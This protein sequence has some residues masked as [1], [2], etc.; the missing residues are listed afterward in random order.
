M[1]SNKLLGLDEMLKSLDFP[2]PAN[3]TFLVLL[4]VVNFRLDV[5]YLIGSSNKPLTL[6]KML[7][8]FEPENYSNSWSESLK[9]FQYQ[10]H[11][12]SGSTLIVLTQPL[13]RCVYALINGYI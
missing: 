12:S 4:S 11:A 8:D 5:T 3:T 13:D 10:Q 7:K 6:Y 2:A 1:C 9:P